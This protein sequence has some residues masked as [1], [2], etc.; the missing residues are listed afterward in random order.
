MATIRITRMARA[1]AKVRTSPG[2]TLAA[3]LVARVPFTRT[4]PP[5]TIRAAS[6]RVLKNRACHSHRSSRSVGRGSFRT[7][8]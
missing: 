5:L 2:P 8:P 3:G 6:E 1:C 4:P 7:C